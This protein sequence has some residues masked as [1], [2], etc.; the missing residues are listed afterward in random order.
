MSKNRSVSPL[1]GPK[2]QVNGYLHKRC[3]MLELE[4]MKME[5][6]LRILNADLE[7]TESVGCAFAF[8][9]AALCEEFKGYSLGTG[10]VLD[11][12]QD[13]WDDGIEEMNRL[14]EVART[15]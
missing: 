13:N 11:K 12:L 2:G 14:A 5:R 4:L 9:V 15:S 8:D 10:A 3:Q 7:M 6:A 1:I